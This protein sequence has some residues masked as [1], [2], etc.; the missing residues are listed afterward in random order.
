MRNVK[1]VFLLGGL[2][3]ALTLSGLTGCSYMDAREGRATGRTSSEVASDKAISDRVSSELKAEPMYKYPDVHVDVFKSTV[4]LSGFVASEDQKR[5]ATDL[6]REV[7]GV[8]QV[9]NDLVVRPEMAQPTGRDYGGGTQ[10]QPAG[11]APIINY[12]QGTATQPNQNPNAN[13]NN[14]N[15]NS[16]SGA[17]QNNNP[18]TGNPNNP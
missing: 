9:V 18:T 15:P 10:K 11:Q 14:N 17:N 2:G 1:G 16:N 4:Q 8:N 6:A 12:N 7:S 5:K 13:P 3:A